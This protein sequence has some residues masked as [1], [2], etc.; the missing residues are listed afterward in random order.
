MGFAT[1]VME[2]MS[3]KGQRCRAKT[4]VNDLETKV[5]PEPVQMRETLASTE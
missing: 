5:C 1:V 2:A 4:A 3:G